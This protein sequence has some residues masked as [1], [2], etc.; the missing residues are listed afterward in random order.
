MIGD[1]YH[2]LPTVDSGGYQSP[3]F[4]C[5]PVKAVP[6]GQ[7]ARFPSKPQQLAA[8]ALRAVA[9]TQVLC[10]CHWVGGMLLSLRHI[11][12]PAEPPLQVATLDS[13]GLLACQPLAC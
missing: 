3:T 5:Q 8:A 9:V 4:D 12:Y 10:P 13:C 11:M 7:W 2:Q 1:Q 6:L